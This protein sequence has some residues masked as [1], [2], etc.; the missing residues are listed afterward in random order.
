M[1]VILL[2][3]G[4][5]GQHGSPAGQKPLLGFNG[6]RHDPPTRS[7]SLGQGYRNYCP[8]LMRFQ[9]PDDLSPF[10][11][12][13]LNTYA[14]CTNDPVNHLD[15]TGHAP[16]AAQL[17]ARMK[18]MGLKAPLGTS[19]KHRSTDTPKRQNSQHTL[20]AARDVKPKKAVNFND[21]PQ[22]IYYSEERSLFK[23]ELYQN[24]KSLIIYMEREYRIAELYQRELNVLLEPSTE[25]MF[26]TFKNPRGQLVLINFTQSQLADSRKRLEQL[27]RT[28]KSIRL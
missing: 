2:A 17:Q 27:G 26:E 12:G 22:K 19:R 7:Y 6:E 8:A 3:Y 21:V 14:Y 11:E 4:P 20:S 25:T 24:R 28:L 16:T 15:P 5:Y 10:A 23:R 13:G 18:Q 1:S 9:V